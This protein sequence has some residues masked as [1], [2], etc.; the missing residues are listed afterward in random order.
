MPR[1]S[2][3]FRKL[4]FR[5]GSLAGII[6]ISIQI[7]QV[8]QEFRS[9]TLSFYIYW[10]IILAMVIVSGS[11][12]Q[13]IEAWLILMRS[14]EVRLPRH[15][16]RFGYALSFLARYIPGTVW[17][18]LSRSEWL[19][20][21]Y[22]VSYLRSNYASL[23]EILCGIFS[24]LLAIGL[25]SLITG[26]LTVSKGLSIS[27][28]LVPFIF[29]SLI[30][31][32]F[33]FSRR[34]KGLLHLEND[35]PDHISFRRW[36]TTLLLLLVNWLYYGMVLF[37]VGWS[38]GAWRIDQLPSVWLPLTIDFSIAWLIGFLIIFIPSG[39]GVRELI[40]S[41]LLVSHYKMAP[42]MAQSISLLMRFCITLAEVFSIVLFTIIRQSTAGEK[43]PKS[44]V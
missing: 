44:A 37:L 20:Q 5:L 13:Q 15:D 7:Y 18:Y 9:G 35:Q 42:G 3:I 40:L 21:N 10:P 11:I 30:L 31:S 24:S 8:F 19:W 14:L 4:L 29:W 17:G 25:G 23:L 27:L 2:K 41:S 12:F 16:A 36:S 43:K 34:I 33:S 38:M 26:D 28:I 32:R 1:S 6:L 39:L 22:Q